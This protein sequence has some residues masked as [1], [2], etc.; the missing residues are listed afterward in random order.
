MTRNTL[1]LLLLCSC[2]RLVVWCCQPAAEFDECVKRLLLPLFD[3][4]VNSGKN[5]PAGSHIY[6]RS[7]RAE[8]LLGEDEMSLCLFEALQQTFMCCWNWFHMSGRPN[9][10]SRFSDQ[11][12]WRKRGK[13]KAPSGCTYLEFNKKKRPKEVKIE[14]IICSRFL[15]PHFGFGL[16]CSLGVHSQRNSLHLHRAQCQW[17][18]CLTSCGGALNIWYL[19]FG[20][21]KVRT[22]KLPVDLSI[23]GS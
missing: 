6:G 8:G 14:K 4:A 10:I 1:T 12:K 13:Q 19:M 9:C 5:T 3:P 20:R 22:G 16:V 17:N 15:R 21:F 11:I 2:A 18:I 23:S 7:D